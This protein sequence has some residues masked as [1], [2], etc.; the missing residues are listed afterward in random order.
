MKIA[1]INK[2][3]GKLSDVPLGAVIQLSHRPGTYLRTNITRDEMQ[4]MLNSSWDYVLVVDVE[5]GKLHWFVPTTS[6][7]TVFHGAQLQLFPECA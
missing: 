5:S 6:V 3:N 2:P 4:T 7:E 1:P